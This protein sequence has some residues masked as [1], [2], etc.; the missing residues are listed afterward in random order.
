M[1]EKYSLKD[2]PYK[3]QSSFPRKDIVKSA[4]EVFDYRYHGAGC[5]FECS[6][7][8]V[9]YDYDITRSN[10]IITSPW[11]F[12]RFVATYLNQNPEITIEE[13]ENA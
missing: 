6:N 8:E 3:C 7:F 12:G 11:K 9:H 4:N 5:S 2:N 10:Y 1:I 13:T